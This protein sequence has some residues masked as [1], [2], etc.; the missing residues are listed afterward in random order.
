M[1]F[2]S[3]LLNV[4]NR[5]KKNANDNDAARYGPNSNFKIYER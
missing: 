4:N 1:C 3:M 5:E 2:S